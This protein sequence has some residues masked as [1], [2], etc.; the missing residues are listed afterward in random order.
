MASYR[1]EV[2]DP[3]RQ[4]VRSL[5]GNMRQRIIR[6]LRALQGEPRP[7]GSRTLDAARAGIPLEPETE[8]RR[9]RIASWRVIYLV[10]DEKLLVTVLAIRQR[11][12]YQYDDLGQLLKNV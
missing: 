5:P 11:P 8:L 9:I 12:P 10:E 3:A 7:A 6:L 2:T 1:V 4:E